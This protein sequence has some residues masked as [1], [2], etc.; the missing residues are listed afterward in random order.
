MCAMNIAPFFLQICLLVLILNR[1]SAK[2]KTNFAIWF[3]LCVDLNKK[4]E[5][6]NFL[7][8]RVMHADNMLDKLAM[9]FCVQICILNEQKFSREKS[10]KNKFIIQCN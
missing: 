6:M 2:K 1:P 5:F 9:H 3:R 4:P 8:N 10:D 7:L